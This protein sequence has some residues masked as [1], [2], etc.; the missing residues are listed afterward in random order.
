MGVG[1]GELGGFSADMGERWGLWADGRDGTGGASACIPNQRQDWAVNHP[2]GLRGIH[3]QEGWR[4]QSC[5]D[6]TGGSDGGFEKAP[7]RLNCNDSATV[8]SVKSRG[9]V[10]NRA[11]HMA[12]V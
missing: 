1:V 4:V 6:G 11:F 9:P 3:W 7:V 8:A 10:Q 2:W 5:Q 12:R